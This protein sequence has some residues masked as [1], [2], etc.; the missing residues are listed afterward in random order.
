MLEKKKLIH[1]QKYW[2]LTFHFYLKDRIIWGFSH[3]AGTAN[4]LSEKQ[5][6][7]ACIKSLKIIN[8]LDLITLLLDLC[9]KEIK[10]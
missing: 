7:N 9:L 10:I 3:V 6:G 1:V 8:V 2:H 4:Y 5:S